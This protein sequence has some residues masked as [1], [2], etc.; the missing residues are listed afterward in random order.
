MSTCYKIYRN[1]YYSSTIPEDLQEDYRKNSSH[2]KIYGS[3]M[4]TYDTKTE[5]LDA[6]KRA[7]KNYVLEKRYTIDPLDPLM[8]GRYECYVWCAEQWT[9]DDTGLPLA[10]TTIAIQDNAPFEQYVRQED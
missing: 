7:P 2:L 10:F 4:G 5:V 1:K 8:S 9:L 3:P 6:L